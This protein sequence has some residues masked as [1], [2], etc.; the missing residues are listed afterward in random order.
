[1]SITL[2]S[3]EGD[4]AEPATEV[5]ETSG[6]HPRPERGIQVSVGNVRQSSHPGRPQTMLF[7]TSSDNQINNGDSMETPLALRAGEFKLRLKSKPPS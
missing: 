4:G 2:T 7:L 3:K 5:R 6:S 1:M